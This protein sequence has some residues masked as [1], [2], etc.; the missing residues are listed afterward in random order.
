M[1]VPYH[2]FRSYIKR[3]QD[4]YTDGTLTL[5]H[6]ELILLATNKFNLLKQ[7]GTLGAKSPDVHK[8]VA[9]QAELTAKGS[10]GK[11]VIFLNT[12]QT[13]SECFKLLYYVPI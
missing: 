5:T 12:P 6:E 4:T 13:T 8:T 2:I 9:M 3:K 10:G 7:E 1:F 11:N